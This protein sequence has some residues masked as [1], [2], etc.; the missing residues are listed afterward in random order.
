MTKIMDRARA[1]G[2][3]AE[4]FQITS[5]E[6]AI[7][8]ENNRL[9]RAET[10]ERA[11]LA[12]R[13]IHQGRIGFATSSLPADNISLL[14]QAMATAAFGKKARFAFPGPG[15]FRD[16][17]V[18][19]APVTKVT[20]EEM[21][22]YGEELLEPLRSFDGKLKASVSLTAAEA[23]V[24]LANTSGLA[25]EARKTVFGGSVGGL[26]VEGENFL[27]VS[28][29]HYSCRRTDRLRSL[30]DRALI[31]LKQGRNNVR[32]NSGRY[33]VLFAPIAHAALLNPILACLNGKAVEK[34]TSPFRGRLGEEA[35]S[36][37]FSLYDDPLRPYFPASAAFDA[38]GIPG[39]RTDL[40][41]GGVLKNFLVDLDTAA[42]LN[43]KPNGNGRRGGWSSPPSPGPSTL[44]VK[45][46]GE[47]A[48]RLQAGIKE[49]LLV[50]HLMGASQ[51]NPYGGVIS[52]N[53]M[54]GFL[55]RDGEVIGRV[56]NTMLSADVFGLLRSQIVNI[57]ND[58]E[59]VWGGMVLPYL[60]V[61]GVAITAKEE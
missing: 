52:G 25:A 39:E 9:K 10:I 15:T 30:R 34:G 7:E 14:E 55:V 61:D 58:T 18:F 49:G 16:V 21:V 29:G 51:G 43:V 45:P 31:H 57:S 48:D 4:V 22:A 32:F 6:T 28:E 8:F 11:G 5:R 41:E 59:E 46:G 37:S 20:P 27:E 19:D 50:Y 17:P 53:I 38:E 35:F 12:V 2:A 13:V 60:L 40:I 56:K 42:A 1:L 33:P 24:S 36:P 23:A 3:H 26:L 44:A 47:P 54:L